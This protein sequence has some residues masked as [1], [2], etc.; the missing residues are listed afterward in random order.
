MSRLLL[1]DIGCEW[2]WVNSITTTRL[3]AGSFVTS[4]SVS[5]EMPNKPKYRVTIESSIYKNYVAIL[6]AIKAKAVKANFDE[7]TESI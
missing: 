1:P 6:K 5:D 2:V 4:I 7:T 3:N